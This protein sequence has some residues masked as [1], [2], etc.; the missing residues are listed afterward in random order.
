MDPKPAA[1]QPA[2]LDPAAVQQQLSRILASKAFRQADRLKRFL[3][4]IVTE[5][6]EGRAE[7]LKEFTVGVEVFGKDRTF[8]A[9]SDPIVRV[10]ARRLRAQLE[11]YYADEA[12]PDDLIIEVPK[13]AYAAVFKPAKEL[14]PAGTKWSASATLVRRN[15]VLV[16]PFSDYT[17]AGDQKYFCAGIS[18]EIINKVTRVEGVRVVSGGTST[19]EIVPSPREAGLRA[20]AAVV[21]TGSVRKSGDKLRVAANLIDTASACYLWSL[22]IDRPGNDV[23]AIQEEIAAAIAENLRSELAGGPHSWGVRPPTQ[24][25][26]AYNFYIQGRYHLNQRTEEALRKAM[27]FFEK[28]IAEDSDFAQ[29][30]S[31]ISD[32]YVLLGHYAVLS[33]AEVWTKAASNAAWAVLKDEHSAEAHTSLAHV[34]ATQDWDWAGAEQEYQRA[35]ALDPRYPTAHHWQ[36]VSL[37]AP[38][39][40]LDEAR[41]EMLLA[42]ALDPTSSIISRDLA[43]I[44]YYIGDF[45]AA[46]EQCDHTIELNPHFTPAYWMLGFVQESRGEFDESSAALQ[47]AMQLG[48][49][50]PSIKAA[51]G[52]CFASSGKKSEAVRILKELKALREKRYVSPF[53]LALLHFALRQLDQGF[54]W[55]AKAFEDR[56]FE[57]ILLKVDPRLNAFKSDKRFA[58]LFSQLRLS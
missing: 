28:A 41:E 20:N 2:G 14:P 24:N 12:G 27:D 26:A 47:R 19:A 56:C 23:F 15:T 30:Y 40:R 37:L 43:R 25:L 29:A 54:E 7:S 8:D 46:L 39:G 50:S 44:Y 16:L 17:S 57:L 1:A 9:R 32:A 49:T 52:H 33:P 10:Q 34:K 38:M 48:A 13:G 11:R 21:V 5:T 55:L 53:D 45:D 31:G 3:T 22:S 36:A 51:L 42:Q 58:S 6:L 4:F 35:I 18:E